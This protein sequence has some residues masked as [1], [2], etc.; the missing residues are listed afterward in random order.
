MNPL[1]SAGLWGA[2]LIA[3]I[4]ESMLPLDQRIAGMEQGSSYLKPKQRLSTMLSTY[5]NEVD[6]G[7][8]GSDCAHIDTS[9]LAEIY[10]ASAHIARYT[11]NEEW[12]ARVRCL[13]SALK[14][15]DMG[16]KKGD[17]ALRDILIATRHFEEA[18]ALASQVMPFKRTLPRILGNKMS[19]QGVLVPVS[20][21]NLQWTQWESRQGWQLVAMVHPLCGFSRRASAAIA[22]QK[23][24]DDLRSRLRM[25]V[26]REAGWY[27]DAEVRE[28]NLLHPELPIVFQA[29][30]QGWG[31]FD[32]YE[33]PV[34]HILHDGK[35]V[36]SISGWT[37]DG[38]LLHEAWGEL[39]H[40]D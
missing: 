31:P 11:A 17:G 32:A 37:D 8:F 38:R 20:N 39:V 2:F 23:R 40:G 22:N 36:R 30:A 7:A 16:T 13:H 28:W 15:K 9:V 24:W 25:V 18:D 1:M 3:G 19:Q 33:T 14:A 5:Y 26:Q 10:L 34:F 21:G 6:P 12:L 35:L 4:G 27:G 29:G